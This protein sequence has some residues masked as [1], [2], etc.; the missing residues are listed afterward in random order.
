MNSFRKIISIK[1]QKKEEI[2]NITGKVKE[3]LQSSGIKEGLLLV[4]SLH[5]SSGVYISDSDTSLNDDLNDLLNRL[6]PES[7]DYKH[8][9][10]D[11]KKN[12]PGHLKVI[13]SSHHVMI[14]V[15]NGK[16]DMGTYQT[17]YYSEFDGMREKEV[18]VKIIG[19]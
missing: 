16:L 4:Y 2:I 14:P 12:A 19:E 3:I 8:N 15:T 6:I 9:L 1:T 13:L 18:L 10:T 5:T 11:Y 7:N 17:I